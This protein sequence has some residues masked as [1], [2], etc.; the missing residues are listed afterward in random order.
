[1]NPTFRLVVT[2]LLCWALAGTAYAVLRL[3][4]GDRPVYIHVRWAPNIGDTPRL[5]LEQRYQLARA[6]PRGNRTFGY[7]LTDRSRDNIRNL[8]LDPAVEDTHEIH[9][10][11]FRVGY[12]APR[13]EYVTPSP[14]IPV[15]L[16]FLSILGFLTGL[17]SISLGLLERTAPGAAE[18]AVA[19][20]ARHP[21]P[22]QWLSP[23]LLERAAPGAEKQAIAWVAQHPTM[24][25]GLSLLLVMTVIGVCFL[26]A[27]TMGG[28]ADES[29]HY[30]QIERYVAG[31][32]AT[33][34]ET[35]A[36][37]GGFHA[38]AT[39]F[40]RLTGNS[41]KEDIRLFVL[42]ISGA[43]MLLFWSLVRSFEPQASTMRTLQFVFFPLLF[44][45]WFL[46]YTDVYALLWLL[47]AILALTQDRVHVSGI[48]MIV[49]VLVRQ[50]YIVWLALLGLWT[51]T[52]AAPL[53]Q[54]ATRGTSFGIGAGLFLL[55]V[56]AN[57]GVAIG[58]RGSNPDFVFHTENLL[59]M[60]LCFF[61]MFLPLILSTLPQIARLPPA[62]LVGVLLSSV[63]LYFGTFRV[64]H[65]NNIGLNYFVRNALLE[66][67]T[68]STSAGVVTSVAIALAVLSLCVIR[69]RQ[70]V[71][72][73]IYPFAVF[74]VMPSWLIEQRYYLP[75][76]ALFMLFRESASPRVERALLAVNVVMALSL[77]VGITE[78]WFFL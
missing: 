55:F 33:G 32:Y 50:T 23:R 47:L 60:L 52:V 20:I 48:L 22:Q 4:F 71:Q 73:L 62:L 72:Y 56:V 10:T 14:G 40:G 21:T 24:Q 8:V 53:R 15:G 49:S 77:F 1:M 43:T 25:Q 18:K 19:T 16:E 37:A 12:F 7:A 42:L 39:I 67:M 46:I 17:A 74:S 28:R 38:S 6:E 11:A 58:D 78:G 2:G 54:L 70:P 69:L 57:G 27:R 61:A 26:A 66:T 75:A 9:R 44:P 45:F 63:G 5:Q 13:L 59:F 76:F 68:A 41:T 36:Q 3:T 64:D 31:N 65:P 35:V 51:V 29:A 30:A 34:S